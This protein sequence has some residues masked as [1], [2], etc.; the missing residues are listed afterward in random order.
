[1]TL[2]ILKAMKETKVSRLVNPISNCAYPANG[3]YFKEKNFWF[4]L[5]NKKMKFRIS[6]V[7]FALLR[8]RFILGA[9]M[10]AAVGRRFFKTFNF[11]TP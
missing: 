6:T 2:N 11:Q 9:V 1:M 3:T 5:F 4:K 10:V 8:G 7:G